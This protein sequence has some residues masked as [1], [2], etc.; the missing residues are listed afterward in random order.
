MTA[1]QLFDKLPGEISGYYMTIIKKSDDCYTAGYIGHV[2]C[3][4]EAYLVGKHFEWK[5]TT[6]WK[7]LADIYVALVTEGYM[8]ELPGLDVKHLIQE[9]R[10]ELNAKL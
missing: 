10:K 3:N 1:E 6:L 9:F 8:K 4:L 5:S 2:G 7:V